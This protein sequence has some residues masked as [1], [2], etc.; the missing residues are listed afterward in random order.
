[1]ICFNS[2][3][4]AQQSIVVAAAVSRECGCG[5]KVRGWRRG[6]DDDDDGADAALLEVRRVETREFVFS[7]SP[8]AFRAVLLDSPPPPPP[9]PPPPAFDTASPAPTAALGPHDF[10]PEL[11]F[12]DAEREEEGASESP[13]MEAT[14]ARTRSRASRASSSSSFLRQCRESCTSPRK[15]RKSCSLAV[16]PRGE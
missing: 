1:V 13:E 10:A 11:R 15:A 6:D 8:Q 4:E 16:A 7:L 5:E 9:P 2:E 3:G 12:S 14:I